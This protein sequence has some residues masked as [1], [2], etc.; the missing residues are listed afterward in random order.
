MSNKT[1]NRLRLILIFVIII[2]LSLAGFFLF[3][4]NGYIRL[5]QLKRDVTILNTQIDKLKAE[6]ARLQNNIHKIQ[7]D[8]FEIEKKA[9][10]KGGLSKKGEKILKFK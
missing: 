2:F 3:G 1:E 10:D 5:L 8:L 6:N 9:R 7:T 4:N